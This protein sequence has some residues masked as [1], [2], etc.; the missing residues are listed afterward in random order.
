MKIKIILIVGIILI[1]AVAALTLNQPAPK[2]IEAEMRTSLISEVDL[3]TGFQQAD[4]KKSLKFPADLGPHT[5]YQTEWWYYTGNLET[6]SGRN[7]GYQLTF[8]RRA[9]V[10]SGDRQ[11]R[12]SYWASDQ[13]YMAHFA[14]SDPVSGD[15]YAYERFSRAG[16]GLA[17]AA[18]EPFQVWLEN[19]QVQQTDVN[20]YH[21]T[22][23]NADIE[24]D[25]EL[26]DVKKP[27]LHGDQGYSRKGPQPGNASYYFS[28][29]RLVSSGWIGI[30]G[31][32]FFVDGLSWMDHEFSS[33]ALSS[34]QTGWDWFSIQLDEGSELMLFLIRRAD[35]TIDPHSSGTLIHPNGSTQ[36]L[37]LDD[38]EI[39]IEDTWRSQ[40]TGAEYPVQ[41]TIQVPDEDLVLFLT[42]YM[43]D[44]EMD[45]SYAY[46]EGAVEV[47]GLYQGQQVL[48][49]GFVE[50]TGYAESIEGEF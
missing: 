21:L 43:L 37:H 29:T 11:I 48:G 23:Q 3:P 2:I 45:L 32:Q 27:I 30:K 8:F 33:S 49:S 5:G 1:I 4:G 7:F 14:I 12:D 31:E 47:S 40:K 22:A 42:P 24:I 18:A 50:M 17:G 28:Q 25:L 36:S 41:W 35:G 13:V 6:K 38:F 16:A 44:Q 26:Q 9:L 10:P 20:M 19:W 46:W 15:H 34:G 39:I